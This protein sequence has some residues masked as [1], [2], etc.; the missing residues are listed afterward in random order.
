MDVEFNPDDKSLEIEFTDTG[1][2]DG[3]TWT[4]TIGRRPTR[5]RR[6]RR[7]GQGVALVVG[8][9]ALRSEAREALCAISVCDRRGLRHQSVYKTPL[10]HAQPRSLPSG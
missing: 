5:T 2:E 3:A 8:R 4:A 7:D 6:R 10:I 1:F 9:F